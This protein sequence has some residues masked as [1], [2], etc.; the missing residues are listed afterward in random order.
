MIVFPDS[1][2][3]PCVLMRVITA[4]FKGVL[5]QIHGNNGHEQQCGDCGGQ[6]V[7]GGERRYK[8]INGNRKIQ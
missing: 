5:T 8:K 2:T 6:W 7:G 4:H 3:R 1:K